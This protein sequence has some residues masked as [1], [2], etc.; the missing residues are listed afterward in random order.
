MSKLLLFFIAMFLGSGYSHAERLYMKK[1]YSL[2]NSTGQY[3]IICRFYKQKVHVEEWNQGSYSH[4]WRM[5]PYTGSYLSG[6][7]YSASQ[8]TLAS[9]PYNICDA[10]SE[11][12]YGYRPSG[13]SFT[14]RKY[15]DCGSKYYYRKGTSATKLRNIADQYCTTITD[16]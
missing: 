13:S 9:K 4:E 7:I 6:L 11:S 16:P 15:T 10:G 1:T 2:Y 5:T 14:L 8:R 3:K 12:I